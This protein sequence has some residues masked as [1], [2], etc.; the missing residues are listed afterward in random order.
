ME[1]KWKFFEYLD[2]FVYV[3][4]MDTDELIYMNA[5]LRK[6]LDIPDDQ[7]YQGKNVMPFF[8][9]TRPNAHFAI[10]KS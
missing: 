4:N 6:A 9:T 3:T 7:T 2:E 5:H 8:S 10:T 1:E